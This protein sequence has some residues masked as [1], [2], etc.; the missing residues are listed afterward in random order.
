MEGGS[1]RFRL[2]LHAA[3]ERL[4]H[5]FLFACKLDDVLESCQPCQ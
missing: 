5:C 4:Q 2:L 1:G 3:S